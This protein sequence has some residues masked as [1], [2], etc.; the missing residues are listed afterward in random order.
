MI[1]ACPLATSSGLVESCCALI[2]W[3]LANTHVTI[4]LITVIANGTSR[5]AICLVPCPVLVFTSLLGAISW[6]IGGCIPE[7]ARIRANA[8][9]PVANASVIACRTYST[10]SILITSVYIVASPLGAIRC[11]VALVITVICVAVAPAYVV[12]R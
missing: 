1:V 12:I 9:V 11:V 5:P 8:F 4:S 6:L 3:H 10:I 2:H 7:I